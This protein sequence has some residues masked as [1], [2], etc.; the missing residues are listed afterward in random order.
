MEHV[1]SQLITK[2][3]ELE[4][5]YLFHKKKLATLEELLNATNLLIRAFNP[6]INL[7][8]IKPK[9][10]TGRK[11]YFKKGESHKMI[12]D[13]FRNRQ[14]PMTTT[15]ITKELMRQ[16]KLNYDEQE[17]LDNV[18]KSVLH[19]LKNQQKNNLIQSIHKDSLN[20][21]TWELCS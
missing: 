3:K 10:Y 12:L 2:R 16:K 14:E 21:F 1:V 13:L 20:G 7:E 18:Q 19:T 11:R 17:L 5:E 4:G 9:R 8:D 6:L 15:D